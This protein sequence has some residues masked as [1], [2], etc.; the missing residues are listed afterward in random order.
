MAASNRRDL[1]LQVSGNIDGLTAAMKAGR[2]VLNE[3]GAAADNTAEEVRKAFDQLGGASTTQSARSIEQAYSKTFSAIRANAQ[4]VLD[5]TN[6]GAAIQVLN[7][8]AA[9]QA[10]AA[11]ET[12]AAGLRLLADA[13]TRAAQA[14]EGDS[15]A[16]RV[17]ATAAEAAAVGAERETESLRT[18]AG[19][20]ANVETELRRAGAANDAHGQAGKRNTASAGQQ[21]AAMQQ[22][23][24]QINDVAT[25]FSSGTPPMQIFAQQS[26]QV[27]QALSLMTNSTKGFLG[28]LGGPWG[29]VTAAAVVV[30]VPLIAKVLE[31]GDAVKKET[32]AL[33]EN[34]EKAGV[35][36][37][38]KVAFAK[39]EAGAIDDVRL[40]T[41]EIKKQNEALLTN[42]E[43]LNIR[44][45][46]RLQTLETARTDVTGDLEKARA[47]RTSAL[48]S[49]SQGADVTV[50]RASAEITVL[51]ARLKKINEVI[52]AAKA[53]RLATQKDL[54][55]ESSKRRTDPIARINYEYDGANG[56]IEQAKKRATAEETVNGV[57]TRRLTLLRTEKQTKIDTANKAKSDA[58]RTGNNNQLGRSITVDDARAIVASIG[59]RVTSGLRSTA[60]QERIYADK[61]AGRHAGPVA[62]PGTSDHEKGQAVDI[63]YGPGITIAKIREA[64]AKQG[65]A[66]RQILDEPAQRVFHVAFGKKGPSQ[67][68]TDNKAAAEARKR[69]AAEQKKIRDEE[70][71]A[72]LKSRAQQDLLDATRTQASTLEGAAD[73]DVQ[74]LQ[75]ERA[76]LDSAAQAGVAEKRW[77]QAKADELKA[78]NASSA[79]LKIAG[80]RDRQRVAMAERQLDIDREDIAGQISLLELQGDLATTAKDRRRIALQI[81]DLQ[82]REARA[83]L[84]AAIDK[85]KDP[86]R[87]AGLERELGRVEPE[88]ADRRE[89]T[90]RS[91]AGPL[92][93]YRADLKKNTDDMNTALQGVAVNGLQS[94]ESGLLGIL[95]GTE[96]VK[97]AFKRMATSIIAD[98]ARIAIEKA[99]VSAIGGSFFGFAKGG[100][101]Q[102]HAT[103]GQ[104]FGAGTGTS[105]DILSWLSNG[106]FVVTAEATRKNLPLLKAINDNQLPAFATGGIV[107]SMP[108][109]PNVRAAANDVYASRGNRMQLDAN[110]T[111]NAGPE[112][113][114]RMEN[115]SLRTVTA[116]AEPIM[117]GATSRT[118]RKLSRGD[119]PGGFE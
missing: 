74:T 28:F 24:F 117:A 89:Q 37:K 7:S 3:F 55:D 19:V 112:F 41:E 58:S 91:N 118:M 70:A 64:F 119:L 71:Y 16:A 26:G 9:T 10:V 63:A 60:D 66:L 106:E 101:V 23:G 32:D 12:R 62:K 44:S 83:T 50:A 77:T 113:D 108:S 56:L 29:A 97:S 90:E 2:S 100:E 22:L 6:G 35:A 1:Y 107:G 109:L 68:Q 48:Q 115:V 59:G 67:E 54:V 49:G 39:T 116:T 81:L 20:L 85:E 11:S 18:Q 42:A 36:E 34:A 95:D 43:R 92:D 98:L 53:D 31:S 5:A 94:V 84:Q 40:L 78:L 88:F 96:S 21:R 110:V 15:T 65:V 86:L 93:Q 87:K 51:E 57:L 8:N 82:E 103:G 79:D 69:E 47:T 104:I 76:R 17:Y 13:A 25:Q 33:K 27:V 99:I 14:T 73:L 30:L 105:D 80:V 38:A 45:K 52:A 111:V 61:L 72:Q 102:A 4:S 114:A 75:V 46:L